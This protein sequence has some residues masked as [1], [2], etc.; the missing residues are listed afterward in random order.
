MKRLSEPRRQV[1]QASVETG[2]S[3]PGREL[4][5]P[6]KRVASRMVRDGLVQWSVPDDRPPHLDD[7]TLNITDVGRSA[8]AAV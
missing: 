6:A 3:L 1:L 5:V 8:Q 4:S 7:W 2:G